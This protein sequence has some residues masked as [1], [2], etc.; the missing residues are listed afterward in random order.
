MQKA[1][2]EEKKELS[3]AMN[4]KNIKFYDE[5]PIGAGS[6]DGVEFIDELESIRATYDGK[7]YIGKFWKEGSSVRLSISSGGKSLL[8]HKEFDGSPIRDTAKRMVEELIC[9]NH[10]SIH[11]VDNVK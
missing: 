10:T 2:L 4:I 11:G 8:K 3:N 5:A 7:E 6:V 9:T 1:M